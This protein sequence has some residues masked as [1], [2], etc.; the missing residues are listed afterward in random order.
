M[1]LDEE[2][3][4]SKR[5]SSVR[6]RALSSECEILSSEINHAIYWH[7]KFSKSLDLFETSFYQLSGGSAVKN[8]QVMQKHK[9]DSWEKKKAWRSVWQPPPVCLSR[10]CHG[11]RSLT[12]YGP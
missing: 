12:G 2:E 8:L 6:I 1:L 11:Q 9:F 4:L 5:S 10:K 3:I 7:A